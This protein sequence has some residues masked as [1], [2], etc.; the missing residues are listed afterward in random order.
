MG[1][2]AR[3]ATPP[4]FSA[5]PMS[6]AHGESERERGERTLFAGVFF[7]VCRALFLSFLPQASFARVSR[8]F[9]P[10]LPPPAPSFP[11]K[12]DVRDVNDVCVSRVVDGGV[13]AP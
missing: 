13:Y 12:V 8:L 11:R 1:I 3:L 5:A 6:I 7:S 4:L 10:L 9:T 2:Y